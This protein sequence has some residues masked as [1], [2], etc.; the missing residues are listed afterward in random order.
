MVL[1]D[2]VEPIVRRKPQSAWLGKAGRR[3]GREHAEE[4]PILRVIFTHGDVRSRCT[5]R[6]FA[7]DDKVAIGRHRHIEWTEFWILDQM[8]IDRGP[9]LREHCDGVVALTRRA[10]ARVKVKPA[11]KAE[12]EA[13]RVRNNVVREQRCSVIIKAWRYGEHGHPGPQGHI[14]ATIGAKDGAPWVETRDSP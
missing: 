5:K 14:E 6:P 9:I 11:V 12:A 2:A 4:P 7:V 13:S 1:A 10:D 8:G 3:I